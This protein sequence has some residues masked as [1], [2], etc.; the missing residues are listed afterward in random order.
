MRNPRILLYSPLVQL[1]SQ[2]VALLSVQERPRRELEGRQVGPE[3]GGLASGLRGL[4]PLPLALQHGRAEVERARVA[5]S[6]AEDRIAQL[7]RFFQRALHENGTK[8]GA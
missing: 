2:S 6:A 4:V 1:K 5:R 7:R 3:A 8:G